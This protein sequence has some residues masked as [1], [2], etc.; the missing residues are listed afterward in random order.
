MIEQSKFLIYSKGMWPQDNIMCHSANLITEELV[1]KGKTE[2]K[3]RNVISNEKFSDFDKV[4]RV[5]CYMR[6]FIYNCKAIVRK[7]IRLTGNVIDL[8]NSKKQLL[9]GF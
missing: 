9:E 5:L 8:E 6:R 1:N 4:I 2:E 3:L 7:E